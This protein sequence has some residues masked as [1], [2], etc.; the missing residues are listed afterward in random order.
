MKQ[1]EHVIAAGTL[2]MVY[3]SVRLVKQFGVF[4]FAL[5]LA[6]AGKI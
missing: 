4:F 6:Q 1:V 2:N 5:Y 3:S